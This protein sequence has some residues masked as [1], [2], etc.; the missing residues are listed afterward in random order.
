MGG[1]IFY[2]ECSIFPLCLKESKRNAWVFA[3]FNLTAFCLSALGF[4]MDFRACQEFTKWWD[5]VVF[6]CIQTPNPT[7]IRMDVYLVLFTCISRSPLNR[8]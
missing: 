6:F 5:P 4:G 1:I 7:I 3:S 2:G 8:Q